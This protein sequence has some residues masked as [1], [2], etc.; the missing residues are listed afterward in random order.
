[1]SKKFSFSG[2]WCVVKNTIAGFI[3]DNVPKLGG[4]LA[5]ATIFSL[6]PLFL[7]ILTIVGRFMGQSA[8]EGELHRQLAGF[9]GNA[10]ALQIEELVKNAWQYSGSGFNTSMGVIILFV[11]ATS[12]FAEI[13]DSINKIW[14]IKPKPKKGWLQFLKN[15]VLSF[16]IIISIGFLLL[17]SLILSTAIDKLSDGLI[18]KYPGIAVNIFHAINFLFNSIVIIGLIA[19]IYKVLPDAKIKWKD[20]MAG[21]ITTALLFMAGRYLISYYINHSKINNSF[22]AAASLVIL[23]IWVYYSAFILYFGAEFTKA[24]AIY[25][26]KNIYPNRF[27]VS[28]KIVEVE[29][30]GEALETINKTT[31][32]ATNADLA[33]AVADTLESGIP[34]AT[35]VQN[36]NA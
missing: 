5:Y 7:I 10:T 21:A 30:R 16:S 29:Q 31:V 15:R 26:G 3:D 25:F 18:L 1:M 22:G 19:A 13:Q 20:V 24:W 36:P 34:Q 9:F 17:V 12:V 11:G 4:S 32:D 8:A 35:P 33:T 2:L 27:A 28:V 23:L 6:A 14:G